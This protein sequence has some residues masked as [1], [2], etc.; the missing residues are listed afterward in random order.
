MTDISRPG[1]PASASGGGDGPARAHRILAFALLSAPVYILVAVWF[2]APPAEEDLP[3]WVAAGAIALV[4]LGW[5][6]AQ[7]V[8][9]RAAPLAFGDDRALA[10]QRYQSLALLRFVVT[11]VPVI[12]GVAAAFALPYGPWPYVVVLVV[13][14]PSMVLQ[15]WPSRRVVDRV[16]TRLESSGVPSGLREAFGHR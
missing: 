7:T 8:G 10:L 15:V 16:A 6:L 3:T 13:G 9:F 11:E 5:L 14:L 1:G 2:A 12:A 4:A